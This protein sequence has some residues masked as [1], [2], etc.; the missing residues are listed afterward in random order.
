[1]NSQESSFL[2]SNLATIDNVNSNKTA[3]ISQIKLKEI[4]TSKSPII[5][6][7]DI[8]RKRTPSTF[9]FDEQYCTYSPYANFGE[10]VNNNE[11]MVPCVGSIVEYLHPFK[12]EVSIGVVIREAQS[13]FNE[14][15]NKL[16]V[17]SFDNELSYVSPQIC[18]L[19]FYKVIN[20]DWL[21]TLN[22]LE[23]RFNESYE[24]RNYIVQILNHFVSQS[25]VLTHSIA[26]QFD[27]VH[28]QYSLPQNLSC[29]SSIEIIES[30]KL[31][32]SILAKIDQSY[33]QQTL[34]LMG[35]HLNLVKS[36]KW[37]IPSIY[38]M[39]RISNL[40][41]G[42]HSNELVPI[43]TYLVN[44]IANSHAIDKFCD[45][46][47]NEVGI[48][49][50]DKFLNSLLREQTSSKS[51]SFEELN[52]YINI[53]EGSTYKYLIE[54]LK[55]TV[56]YP[57]PT[58]TRELAKFSLFHG[59][60]TSPD[61]IYKVLSDLKIYNN[62]KNQLSDIYLSANL[63]GRNKLSAL[64]TSSMNEIEPTLNSDFLH[65]SKLVD[66][67]PHL[68]K[69]QMFYQDQ[70]VY[71]LPMSNYESASGS[72]MGISLE[73]LNSR[74]Y[75]INIHI[76]DVITKVAPN[77]NL[78]SSIASNAASVRSFS[79]LIDT[80]PNGLFSN[81][82]LDQLKFK[83]QNLGESSS[84]ILQV[85]DLALANPQFQSKP[86][87]EDTTCLTLSFTYNTYEG[88]PFSNV[89]SKVK[90]SFDSLSTVPIKCL[91]WSQ[92]EDCLNGQSEISPFRLFRSSA[93]RLT[94][95][96]S[97]ELKLS[98]DD[99][100]SINFIFN[101]MK[102]HFKIRNLNGSSQLPPAI[103][104]ETDDASSLSKSLS[105]T[106]KDSKHEK[107]ITKINLEAK[108]QQMNYSNS[109]FFIN[110][111]DNFAANMASTYC[112]SNEIP[113]LTQYQDMLQPAN[114]PGPIEREESSDE[115]C[116]LISHNNKL[117]PD[118]KADSYFQTLLSRD[119]DGFVSMPA[120]YIGRNYLNNERIGIYS[121]DNSRHVPRGLSKGYTNVSGAVEHFMALLNQLQLVNH[122]QL[123][124]INQAMLA[125][126]RKFNISERFSYLKRYGYNLN[127]P[128]TPNT[129]NEQVVKITNGNRLVKYLGTRQKVFWTLK[130]LEQKLLEEDFLDSENENSSTS[131]EC[132]LTDV[133]S[134]IED[135]KCRLSK[136]Y[137]TDLDI[138]L[139]VM[140]PTRKRF[141]I[142]AVVKCDKVA[143]LDPSQIQPSLEA[144]ASIVESH[145]SLTDKPNLYPI[146]KYVANDDLTVHQAYLKLAQLNAKDRSPSFLFESAVN[147]DT[148]A[149]YSFI[150]V[151]PKR[152]IKTGEDV[153]KFG[154]G[155]ANVDPITV[156]EKELNNFKQAQLP[157]LPKFSGGATGY[158]S[159]DCIKYFEPKTKRPLKDVLELPEAV[160][161]LCDL[162][163]AFDHVYQR[164]Q[165]INN[166]SVTESE[167]LSANFHKATQEIENIERILEREL[168]SEDINP[169]QPP[170]KMNQTF[171]SNIGQEGY[172]AHVSNLKGHILKGDI[173]QAVP[174]QRVAR[175]TS[176]HPFNIYR[177][178]RTVNP[179]PYLFYI[180]L[181]DFQIIGA[182]PELLVKAD[183]K[184]KVVTH[185]I[186]GTIQR[187]KTT[188]EDEAN[189]EI[190]RKSLK[191]RAE[192][193][194]LVDLARN[195]I[196]RV[197]QP[198]SN[199]VDRLLTIER[200][201]HVMHLVSEVS[202]TLRE[203]QTRF[204]AFRSIFP[205]GTVSGAP[206]VRAME[207]IGEL[208]KEKRGVYAGA[209]GHWSYDGKTMDTC[210]A[211]RTMVYKDGVA[212]LQAGGG[213]VFDSDEYDEYVETM[214][215]MKANNNTI[216]EAETVWAEKVGVAE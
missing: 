189:A 114:Q 128:L 86:A 169:V 112:D 31:S 132:I 24:P 58:L 212:Y 90:I 215:K 11:S 76:P 1:M 191:D 10:I 68:R 174:S 172:E 116:V 140:S 21:K 202:G 88:N 103:V 23:N 42:A 135:S 102:S 115:D 99:S 49:V 44:S 190:L 73:K 143:Y 197:C 181:I 199:T 194:M 120:S 108:E 182:S 59:K 142:G 104:K 193:I 170:I 126:D 150:G 117:L 28:S 180:D 159:Y 139:T 106:N 195:D 124:T 173:I 198:T 204:D 185:P 101:V 25:I 14:N 210:I 64:A 40:V 179:S 69:S 3:E 70:I 113:I 56:V 37:I 134:V 81:K 89:A 18:S 167:D 75:V 155:F 93:K 46:T 16:V 34:L 123:Q 41:Y 9:H 213:I 36:P 178:L 22:I 84:E 95:P 71:G 92:L 5:D 196:N 138:E 66:K 200:F 97:T 145:Q 187:G 43:P 20:Q 168:I 35:I 211:L 30:L 129:L 110:E 55:L 111:L 183:S 149:R 161:M 186:A 107:I 96:S 27:I 203:D 98:S 216:V 164:F 45:S 48:K 83:N 32:E 17:L 141:T 61:T 175:P 52:H 63:A 165:I 4:L 184:G 160:L 82:L 72:F 119:A 162:V 87:S 50:L 176:L 57:H 12:D 188:E 127:G 153:S 54:V 214:N 2:K 65:S 131:Y 26:P 47:K 122:I 148:V 51:R 152:I 136:A 147:G 201:S 62:S 39:N 60:I 205:A 192:H 171:T 208:E 105:I 78:F 118:Y 151:N 166:V 91:S 121:G 100:H 13:K 74:K 130:M 15:Y 146:Y 53:W 206:K 79:N 207:L 8:Y 209:V 154:E 125:S 177:H 137:C 163:I 94:N 29:I 144:L 157:G 38:T 7:Y 156:L 158:I 85:G 109:K 67:F 133:G 19:H 33:Y 80:I 77:S 6:I